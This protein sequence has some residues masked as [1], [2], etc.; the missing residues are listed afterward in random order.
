LVT[1]VGGTEITIG[2]YIFTSGTVGIEA[3]VILAIWAGFTFWSAGS[4]GSTSLAVCVVNAAFTFEVTSDTVCEAV[5]IV[6]VLTFTVICDGSVRVV[7][8]FS[9]G[10]GIATLGTFVKTGLAVPVLVFIGSIV[11]STSWGIRSSVTTGH[12]FVVVGALDTLIG[13]NL[14]LRVNSVVIGSRWTATVG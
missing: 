12:T 8:T 3:V 13:A 11:T 1:T 10:G 4:I 5:I 6:W 14:T 2:E 9:A 7:L